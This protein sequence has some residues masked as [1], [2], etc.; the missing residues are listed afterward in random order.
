[1]LPSKGYFRSLNCPY[2]NN[3]S[4]DR[5][6]CHFR[7]SKK[8]KF[9]EDSQQQD[10]D[11]STQAFEEASRDSADISWQ[12]ASTSVSYK[13]TPI[14]ELKKRHI[15]INTAPS[16]IL[17]SSSQKRRLEYDVRGIKKPKVEYIPEA[18]K[19]EPSLKK[20]YSASDA[21]SVYRATKIC[22]HP[23]QLS[24]GATNNNDAPQQ[25]NEESEGEIDFDQ[26]SSELN[27]LDEILRQYEKP[28]SIKSLL[29]E[30]HTSEICSQ[31]EEKKEHLY[32]TSNLSTEKLSNGFPTHCQSCSEKNN[33][34]S[35][36][37][38]NG[39]VHE[40]K[41]HKDAEHKTKSSHSDTKTKNANN[42]SN[43]VDKSKQTTSSSKTL[44]CNKDE[45]KVNSEHRRKSTEN[46]KSD[47]ERK[48]SKNDPES[49][50]STS[51]SNKKES[52]SDKAFDKLLLSDSNKLSSSEKRSKK[53]HS[54]DK[55]SKKDSE[56]RSSS[57]SSKSRRKDSE[58]ESGSSK[59]KDTDHK[60]G[61]SKSHKK[62]SDQR[63]TSSKSS[64]SQES[65]R[66]RTHSHESHSS[67]KK[68]RDSHKSD[69]KQGDGKENSKYKDE[70][71]HRKEG[72][73]RRSSNKDRSSK[74]KERREK[75][76]KNSE[77]SKKKP[78]HSVSESESSSDDDVQIISES[79]SV[80][81]IDSEDDSNVEHSPAPKKSKVEKVE[82]S[83][84]PA[85]SSGFASPTFPSDVSDN[86]DVE[87]DSTAV[88]PVANG[89]NCLT[90]KQEDSELLDHR[91]Q[92]RMKSRVS[93]GTSWRPPTKKRVEIMT[94]AQRLLLFAKLREQE[95][96]DSDTQSNRVK[97]G[98]VPNV[99]L[100]LEEKQRILKS[101]TKMQTGVSGPNKSYS[102]V[103]ATPPEIK[104]AA[105]TNPITDRHPNKRG[106]DIFTRRSMLEKL[107]KCERQLV[108]PKGTYKDAQD[109][110]LKEEFKIWRATNHD[111]YEKE[112][113]IL[114]SQRK[115]ELSDF[116]LKYFDL[117]RPRY[118]TLFP[119]ELKKK[120]EAAVNLPESDSSQKCDG[121]LYSCLKKFLLTEEQLEAEGYPRKKASST[122]GKVI[123]YI[124][125]ESI[126][127]WKK[128][129]GVPPTGEFTCN[130]CSKFYSVDEEGLSLKR[131]DCSYHA[132][133]AWMT[134]KEKS[135]L[136]GK[137][138][139]CCGNDI[140]N[141][142]MSSEFHSTETRDMQNLD[143]YVETLEP[144]G[145]MPVGGWG[146]FAMDCEMYWST[147]GSELGRVTVVNAELRTV[148]DT[149]VKPEFPVT[150]YCTRM[151][152]LTKENL[153]KAKKSFSEVQADMS[154]LFNNKTI[155]IGH[156]LE[157][158]LKALQIV[159][160][161]V[162][163]TA[164]VFKK[165]DDKKQALKVL[166]SELLSEAI[167]NE[168]GHDSAEDAVTCLKLMLLKV[169]K[170]AAA[171][172]KRAPPMYRE[173]YNKVVN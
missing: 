150:D 33:I 134:S 11:Q 101:S 111:A 20:V 63:S 144:R 53:E 162:V 95:E 41:K 74:D 87:N 75:R 168:D 105:P 24:N 167:Q 131:F 147:R 3:G 13:P 109:K 117:I 118:S 9:D 143:G 89:S 125:P 72:N 93:L 27:F 166:A 5:P 82:S 97:I 156:S 28:V 61:S 67:S 108:H 73:D 148:Y 113:L 173:R 65:S 70:N 1:M 128:A 96:K 152:G 51:K 137:K 18:L 36:D 38:D 133:K 138:A 127:R 115:S 6:H 154:K 31:D 25:D 23:D 34:R 155:L 37:S 56:H 170:E 59:S 145:K 146:V 157:N 78:A 99:Q 10:V 102:T 120:P 141:P 62:E 129:Q 165:S 140:D 94:P 98:C 12:S 163:D 35:L 83:P 161:T 7:H 68:N 132:K 43:S 30:A 104:D 121:S 122:S 47:K 130:N 86:S 91:V 54:S 136:L 158:D 81:V 50:K 44:P 84:S 76:D 171:Q 153:G 159:H 116:T 119:A 46:H 126:N 14:V 58:R 26:V 32:Q 45:N 112:M 79:G 114:M 92:S 90:K 15:P 48:K 71:R 16:V 40:I 142:C 42:P 160:P 39:S 164:V 149:F 29:D 52:E 107:Y 69:H 88:V 85:R 55:S 124:N 49:L 22:N 17:S 106:A 172:S 80:I 4:C 64:K 8:D 77:N 2:F 139:R 169:K 123:A 19:T 21:S 103:V 57:S 110:C 151:S 135:G 100:L 60:D 66:K